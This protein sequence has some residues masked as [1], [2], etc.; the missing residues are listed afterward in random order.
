MMT[1]PDPQPQVITGRPPFFHLK[2]DPAIAVAVLRGDRP[3][4]PLDFDVQGEL[5]SLMEQ[6]WQAEPALRPTAEDV[7]RHLLT[8]GDISLAE[9]WD[10]TLFTELRR[11]M[12]NDPLRGTSGI[13]QALVELVQS[14]GIR[15]SNRDVHTQ[16]PASGGEQ[17]PNKHTAPHNA[18]TQP[19]LKPVVPLKVTANRWDRKYH[20]AVDADS[21]ELV[22]Q[23]VRALLNKITMEKFDSISDQIIVWANMSEN[24]KDGRTLVQVIRLIF[25]KA[26][27]E[28]NFSEMY[29]RLCRK[30]MDRI[31]PQVQDEGIRNVE[32]KPISGGQLFRKYL[33]NRCQEDFERGWTTAAKAVAKANVDKEEGEVA[34]YSNEYYAAQ[35]AKRQ[36]LG[37]VR[38]IGELFK[39]QMLTERIMHE[40]VKK[41]LDHPE[42]DSEIESLWTLLI[43]VGQVLDTAKAKAHMDAYFY[44]I[45]EVM[46]SP[47][48]SPRMQFLLQDMIKLRERRWIA[49]NAIAVPQTIGQIR[50]TT[51]EQKSLQDY[52]HGELPISLSVSQHGSG[53]AN[54]NAV[55]PDSWGPVAGRV[56]FGVPRTHR[57]KTLSEA[58]VKKKIEGDLR[59]F[60]ISRNIDEAEGYFAKL[61][62]QHDHQLLVDGLVSKAVES[63]QADAELVGN[64][65]KRASSENL[66]SPSAFEQAFA[67]I[68]SV[69][70]DTAIDAPNAPAYLAIM[71]KG[72][73]LTDNQRK[74]ITSK[75]E[76]N[77]QKVFELSS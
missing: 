62:S 36:G 60:F 52:I 12:V 40:C 47:N 43:T 74:S 75:S 30:M 33:L 10:S 50:E 29:A 14:L 5:W 15:A 34:L 21:P 73:G 8:F 35:K 7:L 23:K 76:E 32:G 71:L 41:L 61:R 6:C 37:L 22:E 3:S 63:K 53:R 64:L 4:K 49:K 44:R 51:A 11:S 55:G 72:A 77:G 56:S 59:V 9:E 18:N 17:D 19:P 13:P 46:R 65:L 2:R 70:D 25:G 68:A 26:T 54:A 20:N 38:F 1:I 45:K 28:A 42:E 69:L 31:S 39:L 67:S 24:E 57:K 27:D 16:L 66:C 58:D 48:V